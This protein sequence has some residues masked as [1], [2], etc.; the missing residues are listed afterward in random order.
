MIYSYV[1]VALAS[2]LVAGS[3]T[4]KIQ[5]WRHDSAELERRA[6]EQRLLNKHVD[7]I[8]VASEKH[9]KVKEVIRTKFVPIET[10]VERVVSKIEYRNICFDS[11]GLQQLASA[12]AAISPVASQP[13]SAV[14][15][16]KPAR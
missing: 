5:N 10:E 6:E 1:A 4:W 12:I 9:E 11:D 16:S 8:D 15:A 3:A 7:K 13:A 14:P 2:A